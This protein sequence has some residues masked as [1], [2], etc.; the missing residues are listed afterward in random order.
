M[1][2]AATPAR[3]R[4]RR[5]LTMGASPTKISTAS[6]EGS[7]VGSGAVSNMTGDPDVI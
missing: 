2:S 5:M 3:S 6:A 7:Q 4:G 1:A